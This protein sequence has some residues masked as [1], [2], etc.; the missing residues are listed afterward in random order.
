MTFHNHKPL[1]VGVLGLCMAWALGCSSPAWAQ[2]ESANT[3]TNAAEES[4]LEQSTPE[5]TGTT[6][7]VETPE[8]AIEGAQASGEESFGITHALTV[9]GEP[10]YSAGFEY[11]D[12]VNPN[13]PKGGRI[14]LGYFLPFDTVHAFALK[15]TKAPGTYGTDHTFRTRVRDITYDTLMTPSLDEPQTVYGLIAKSAEVATDFSWVEFTLRPEAHWHDGSPITVEDVLFTFDTLRNEGDPIFKVLLGQFGAVEQTGPHKVRVHF[16]VKNFRQLPLIAAQIPILPKKVYTGED[17]RTFD[18][19]TL[20]PALA[21]G[22]YRISEVNQGRSIT[23]E[24]VEDYWAQDLPAMKGQNN[25]DTI[26]FQTFRDSTVALEGIKS[27]RY[28]LREENVS[29]NWATAYDT[30]AVRDGRLLKQFVPHKLPTGNQ[31][32]ILQT[33]RI[34]DRRVREAIGLAFD[35]EWTNR[36][37]FYDAY[38]QNTSF[39]ENTE[40]AARGVPSAE[41]RALLA[42]YRDILP[43][44]LFTEEFR[45]PTTESSDTTIRDNL[46]KAQ[47][48]LNE[49]GYVLNEDGLRVNKETGE[50]LV[51]TF[52]YYEPSFS[53]VFAPMI[54]NLRR[55]GIPATIN[56]VEI[57]QHQLLLDNK[58]FT[59][60]IW[61]FNNGV[62][63]PSIE[64]R[65]YWSCDTADVKGSLNY[66][67][68]CNPAVDAM[69]TK[70]EQAETLEELQTASRALDRILLWEHYTIPQ[71]H[72]KG[73]NLIHWDKFVKP[74][75]PASYDM[76]VSTW[77]AKPEHEVKDLKAP[78]QGTT[79]EGGE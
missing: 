17:A 20:K 62:F 39:F 18:Q 47:R 36:V 60:A 65:N 54:N 16:T 29:R 52:L 41:E 56:I 58:D 32:Y 5:E 73:F 4:V 14:N 66:G 74:A 35:F 25:F 48:L 2:A 46:L 43:P 27:G 15:G 69:I 79:E 6:A 72:K 59:I 21:S 45:V 70:I 63:F 44:R 75:T 42:P 77:W 11:F 38:E 24:R 8:D 19:S 10:K 51:L 7:T 12:Y 34:P 26:H 23:Y 13:A 68:V 28:D 9:F 49:A 50:P 1:L 33:E 76:G 67:K 71:Y 30:P 22:P 3:P 37:I 53:R 31:S 61:W 64:Q 55:L 57:A 78:E 40:F